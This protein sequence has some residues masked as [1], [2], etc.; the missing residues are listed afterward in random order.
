M[1]L[2]AAL[3]FLVVTRLSEDPQ[4]TPTLDAL[5]AEALKFQ[6]DRPDQWAEY[7]QLV[8][9]LAEQHA[10][11]VA[12]W[13]KRSSPPQLDLKPLGLPLAFL[14]YEAR[15]AAEERTAKPQGGANLEAAGRGRTGRLGAYLDAIAHHPDERRLGAL[16]EL[17]DSLTLSK[18][19]G[20]WVAWTRLIAEAATREWAVRQIAELARV[21]P[22]VGAGEPSQTLE[23]QLISR[24]AGELPPDAA[25]IAYEFLRARAPRRPHS[26]DRVWDLLFRVDAPR[27][28]REILPF[29]HDETGPSRREFNITVLQLLEKHAGPSPEVARAAR[30]WLENPRIDPTM[31]RAI[32]VIL[33]RADPQTEVGPS[34]AF[35]DH[36][37][38]EQ[39]RIPYSGEVHY[40]LLALGQVGTQPADDAVARYTFERAIPD[41]IRALL[42]ESVIRHDHPEAAALLT[43]WLAEESPPMQD[44]VRRQAANWGESGR[45]LLQ[46]V[47]TKQ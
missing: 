26:A 25:T 36:Q 27:T 38:A 1:P 11:L 20:E 39:T 9:Q 33:L 42:L 40:L 30:E 22:A 14:V 13:M 29:F 44:A 31:Q 35:I 28:R 41:G 4:P 32:R 8:D 10:Q 3:V 18:S 47:E 24:F 12:Q 34:V 43:R 7:R 2:V 23:F 19:A 17:R 21:A 37:V 6:N 16:L 15:Q 46:Q 45:N 5:R